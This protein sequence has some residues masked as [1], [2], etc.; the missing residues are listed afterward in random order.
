MLIVMWYNTR[1]LRRNSEKKND[2]GVKEASE[3][4]MLENEEFPKGDES[5]VVME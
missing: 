5:L 4:E 3:I 1:D 2:C